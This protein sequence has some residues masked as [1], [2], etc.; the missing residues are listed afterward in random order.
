[1]VAVAR[2]SG[3]QMGP[4]QDTVCTEQ[5][6]VARLKTTMQAGSHVRLQR[7]HCSGHQLQARHIGKAVNAAS[8]ADPARSGGRKGC[9]VSSMLLSSL[10]HTR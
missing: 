5:G 1:M 3:L 2:C 9:G 8:D 10:S 4:M 7:R 6:A